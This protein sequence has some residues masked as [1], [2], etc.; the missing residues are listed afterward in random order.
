MFYTRRLKLTVS[1][2]QAPKESLREIEADSPETV[3]LFEAWQTSAPFFWS[4]LFCLA[5]MRCRRGL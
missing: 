5:E 1:L 2:Q 4:A 3:A